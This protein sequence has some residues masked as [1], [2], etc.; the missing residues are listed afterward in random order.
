MSTSDQISNGN[1]PPIRSSDIVCKRLHTVFFYSGILFSWKRKDDID[2]LKAKTIFFF[3]K[4]HLRYEIL[5]PKV[6]CLS[7]SA[8]SCERPE[9]RDSENAINPSFESYAPQMVEKKPKSKDGSTSLQ[10]EVFFSVFTSFLFSI[11]SLRL[12][13]FLSWTQCCARKNDVA[14][15]CSASHTFLY[16]TLQNSSMLRI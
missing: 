8:P 1:L 9:T 6:M 4:K 7:Q 3:R 15:S 14:S 12:C 16:S 10:N 2:S 13:S 5:R 11:R